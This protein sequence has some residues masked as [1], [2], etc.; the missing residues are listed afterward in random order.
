MMVLVSCG[1]L[2]RGVKF[3]DLL[4]TMDPRSVAVVSMLP[5]TVKFGD[6]AGLCEVIWW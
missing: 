4:Q 6:P 1:D 2:P 3:G 5:S